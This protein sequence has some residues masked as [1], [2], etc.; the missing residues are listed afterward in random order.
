M[1]NQE[2]EIS[3]PP[4]SVFHIPFPVSSSASRES[5]DAPGECLAGGPWMPSPGHLDTMAVGAPLCFYTYQLHPCSHMSGNLERYLHSGFIFLKWKP[6]AHI[7]EV[8]Y[9]EKYFI[10]LLR[11]MIFK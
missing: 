4:Q 10:F 8:N 11:Q 2:E 5:P 9:A 1:Q 6:S 3:E 7:L